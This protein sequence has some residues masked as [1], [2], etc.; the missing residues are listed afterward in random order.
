MSFT[1]THDSPSFRF[2]LPPEPGLS[3]DPFSPINLG[4]GIPNL[5]VQPS[6]D[7]GTKAHVTYRSSSNSVSVSTVPTQVIQDAIA[8]MVS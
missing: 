2:R 8:A 6:I 7:W 4:L 5:V 3:S 1:P